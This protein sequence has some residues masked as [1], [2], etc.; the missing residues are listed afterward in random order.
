MSTSV[1]NTSARA[2]SIFF[3]SNTLLWSRSIDGRCKNAI[4]GRSRALLGAGLGVGLGTVADMTT[5]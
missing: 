4:D 3:S 5:H 1:A 2:S